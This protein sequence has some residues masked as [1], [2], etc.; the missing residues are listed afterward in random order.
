M[1]DATPT[2]PL[3]IARYLVRPRIT[4]L[5]VARNMLDVNTATTAAELATSS[6]PCIGKREKKQTNVII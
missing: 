4:R 3:V 1:V 5:V 6:D 2:L